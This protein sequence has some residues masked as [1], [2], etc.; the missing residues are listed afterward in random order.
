MWEYAVYHPQSE[1]QILD[2][3]QGAGKEGWE[4][5]QIWRGEGDRPWMIF[6]RP[7]RN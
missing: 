3:M 1:N 2:I 5:V 4:L 6:K 7:K